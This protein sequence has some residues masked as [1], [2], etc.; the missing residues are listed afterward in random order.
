MMAAVEGVRVTVATGE[1]LTIIRVIYKCGCFKEKKF[2]NSVN[3][4]PF[5]QFLLALRLTFML[6]ETEQFF[7][8][9]ATC[10]NFLRN[11]CCCHLFAYKKRNWTLHF[12]QFM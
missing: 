11:C 9:E 7:K 1:N 2:M 8:L 3:F 4:G 6:T 10:K 12:T 5:F